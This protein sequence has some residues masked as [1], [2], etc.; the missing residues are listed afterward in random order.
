MLNILCLNVN[1]LRHKLDALQQILIDQSIDV[2]CLQEHWLA[3]GET[4]PLYITLGIT[5]DHQNTSV[6]NNHARRPNGGI[7][8]LISSRIN[9][10]AVLIETTKHFIHFKVGD[11]HFYNVYISPKPEFD[12]VTTQILTDISNRHDNQVVVCG[13]AMILDPMP[14]VIWY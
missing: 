10:S 8:V 9:Q 11:I 5:Y 12:M 7:A 1:G 14:A 4:I 13:F 6:L 3:A 2:C